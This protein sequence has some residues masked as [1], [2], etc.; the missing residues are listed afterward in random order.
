ME[1][2]FVGSR[3]KCRRPVMLFPGIVATA[4]MVAACAV[5]SAD[6]ALGRSALYAYYRWQRRRRTHRAS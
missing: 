5:V 6:T 3:L 2:K 4:F 1:P